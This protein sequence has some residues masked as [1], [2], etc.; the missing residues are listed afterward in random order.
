MIDSLEDNPEG[1]FF[2]FFGTVSNNLIKCRCLSENVD[3][4]LISYSILRISRG[5]WYLYL[6]SFPFFWSIFIA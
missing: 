5:C 3:H 6:V 2:F 4:V 1:F